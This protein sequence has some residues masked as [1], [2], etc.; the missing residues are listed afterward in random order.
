M[1][2]AR[3]L[4]VGYGNR[5]I[6]EFVRILERYKIKYLVDVRSKPY[7]RVN[8]DFSRPNLE[9]SL[10]QNTVKYVFMGDALGGRPQD[11]SC[12]ALDGRVDYDKCKVQ[13]E[14]QAGLDRLKRAANQDFGV[15]IMCSELR[16]QHC[17]RSKLIGVSL[18]DLGIEVAHIDERGEVISQAQVITEVNAELDRIPPGQLSLFDNDLERSLTSRKRYHNAQEVKGLP[19]E[20]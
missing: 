8:P 9:R 20:A 13:P 1:D 19:D 17:H 15:V 3:I 16:P 10:A 2:M 7:S 6:Q 4:T 14:Y 11:T 18:T 12:Y 5:T